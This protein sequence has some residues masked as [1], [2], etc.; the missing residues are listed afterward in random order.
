LILNEFPPMDPE[1]TPVKEFVEELNDSP[2]MLPLV[3]PVNEL[4]DQLSAFAK[5]KVKKK[6]V[7]RIIFFKSFFINS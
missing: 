3:T 2:P 7:N 4:V 5:L 6:N 1:V